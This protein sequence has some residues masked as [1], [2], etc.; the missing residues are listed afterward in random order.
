ML[1]QDYK[2]EV[3]R[4]GSRR[5]LARALLFLLQVIIRIVTHFRPSQEVIKEYG[6]G[7][8]TPPRLAIL[9]LIEGKINESTW[10][11]LTSR[12][13]QLF[14][15]ALKEGESTK[16]LSEVLSEEINDDIQH[17]T[18]TALKELF[19][20]TLTPLLRSGKLPMLDFTRLDL[21]KQYDNVWKEPKPWRIMFGF[22]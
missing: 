11:S 18:K 13:R 6:L 3:F 16:R 22:S 4:R 12:R 19:L 1:R 8:S 21:D 20:T 15:R 14:L 10:E 9:F 2:L 5:N 7:V 17:E